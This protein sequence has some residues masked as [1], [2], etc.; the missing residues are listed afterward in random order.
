MQSNIKSEFLGCFSEVV[1]TGPL[2]DGMD[3]RAGIIKERKELH[4]VFR[5]L[6]SDS[7][8]S[9][10]LF[11]AIHYF[12]SEDKPYVLQNISVI[13]LY[14]S[15]RALKTPPRNPVTHPVLSLF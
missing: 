12:F 13:L 14:V 2:P 11:I 4:T 15:F 9:D 1:V 10:E 7:F 8:M 6:F 3:L 5:L